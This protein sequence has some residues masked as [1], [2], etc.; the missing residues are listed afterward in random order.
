[1]SN[2]FPAETTFG[3]PGLPGESIPFTSL[4]FPVPPPPDPRV[5][6][7]VFD[8]PFPVQLDPIGCFNFSTSAVLTTNSVTGP[9]IAVNFV[10]KDLG[11]GNT[12]ACEPTLSISINIPPGAIP[13]ICGPDNTT[14]GVDATTVLGT[15]FGLIGG[16][17]QTPGS[18]DFDLDLELEFACTNFNLSS[19]SVNIT[20]TKA[21]DDYGSVSVTSLSDPLNPDS[22]ASQFDIDL[23][24]PCPVPRV[25]A[26]VHYDSSA[27]IPYAAMSILTPPGTEA[28]A[29]TKNG[30]VDVTSVLPTKFAVRAT[31][32][33]AG[34]VNF[35]PVGYPPNYF[36]G[37]YVEFPTKWPGQRFAIHSW[38]QHPDPTVGGWLI[39]WSALP[40]PYAEAE[41]QFT[42]TCGGPNVNSVSQGLPVTECDKL[43]TL[44]IRIP[45]PPGSDPDTFDEIPVRGTVIAVS[46]TGANGE[47]LGNA[48]IYTVQTETGVLYNVFNSA[49]VT[50]SPNLLHMP[51]WFGM[52]VLVFEER[53]NPGQYYFHHY[54]DP[55]DEDCVAPARATV[56]SSPSRA[57]VRLWA[58]PAGSVKCITPSPS[59]I[60]EITCPDMEGLGWLPISALSTFLQVSAP[61]G[62]KFWYNI[63]A[64]VDLTG[65]DPFATIYPYA[66]EVYPRLI[67]VEVDGIVAR[68][69]IQSQLT[70][71]GVWDYDDDPI[72][73]LTRHGIW[74]MKDTYGNVPWS[75]D[76]ALMSC[77]NY[78]SQGYCP[79]D[80]PPTVDYYYPSFAAV[81]VKTILIDLT[82]VPDQ[83]LPL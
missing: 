28:T 10:P 17:T 74:W 60:H 14:L 64:H 8:I 42:V 67:H 66:V 83:E 34:G 51:V 77:V 81:H 6:Y 16:F 71:T 12:D 50:Y 5:E 1:M 70:Y 21:W 36:H 62:A 35:Q 45:L 82:Y 30:I 25:G 61:V 47:D 59:A 49:A 29:T 58:Y 73:V 18:C 38:E 63:P 27:A 44:D 79:P 33:F 39:L 24:L 57:R 11:G 15:E 32:D 9:Q 72:V 76:L 75:D 4:S 69:G 20:H 80:L 68:Q 48:T 7:D 3:C 54:V 26:M 13:P 37:C 22:C 40:I 65:Q 43:W 52:P 55:E 78:E 41:D 31:G 23:N 53:G 46:D 19:H 2:A 56:S